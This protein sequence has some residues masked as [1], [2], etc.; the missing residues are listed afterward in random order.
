[1]KSAKNSNLL[2][3]IV[4]LFVFILNVIQGGITELLPDEAYYWV[5]REHIDW[6]FFDH[7]PAVAVWIY[8]SDL[9]FSGEM[10]VR[11]FSALS[12]SA[13]LW[14]VWKTI[15]HPKKKEYTWLFLIVFLS[16]VLLSV[17]GFITTPDA[18]LMTFFAIFLYAYHLYLTKKNTLSYLLLSISIAG[19]MYSKYQGI[20]IVFFVILSNFKLMRDPK[21]W[22]A[23]LFALVLYFPHLYW[24]WANDFPSLKF[25]L[26]ERGNRR[27]KIEHT[28]LH[29]VNVMVI[30]GITFP[31]IYKAFFKGQ[32][33]KDLFHRGLNFI[34]WGF[35]IFFF[36]STFKG[37]TQAQW[38]LAIAIPLV[39]ITVPFLIENEKSR[40]W[41]V[42][43]ACINFAVMLVARVQLVTPIFPLK[44]E[45]HGN[46]KWANELKEKT[47]GQ[48]K[49]FINSYRHTAA[50]WFYAQEQAY[51]LKNYSGRNN[52]FLLLQKG[53]DISSPEIA[54]I[55]KVREHASD[56]GVQTRQRDSIF[57]EIVPN[58]KDLSQIE[59]TFLDEEIVLSQQTMNSIPIEIPSHFD[60]DVSLATTTFVAGFMNSTKKKRLMLDGSLTSDALVLK[61]DIPVRATLDFLGSNLKNPEIHTLIG[62]GLYNSDQVDIIRVSNQEKYQLQD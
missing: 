16:S 60:R 61:K 37:H 33:T 25:H 2:L 36:F 35:I 20:L 55:R 21:L 3:F 14:F 34:I 30:V 48:Q 26:V 49:V 28:L 46:E 47:K 59:V 15:D 57:A 18:A 17:Y 23:S 29:F 27:Y 1:M 32:K 6:G 58:F 12:Y 53:K 4:V 31:I 51:Y 13:T 52:H 11:F 56:I 10:G 8:L 62:V 7:P 38:I 22:L 54:L 9:F 44:M 43:L 19:M 39:L 24:Q 45:T 5:Y 40:K 42:Y 41:F 50:Y